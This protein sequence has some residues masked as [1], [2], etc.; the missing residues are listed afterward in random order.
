MKR[1]FKFLN[2]LLFL[3]IPL[4]LLSQNSVIILDYMKVEPGHTQDYLEIEKEWKKL[5]QKKIEAGITTGWQLWRN[6]FAGADDPYQFITINW[7]D[8]FAKTSEEFPGGLLDDVFTEAEWGALIEKTMNSRTLVS[9]EVS[10]SLLEAEGSHGAKYI[11]INHMKVK[12]DM[13]GAYVALESEIWKPFQEELIKRDFKSHWGVWSI[14]PYKEGQARYISVDGYSSMDQMMTGEDILE[15]VHPG[16]TWEEIDKKTGETR[17]IS[18]VEV[19]ELV[20]A[21]FPE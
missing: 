20:D 19:W 8:N 21:V 6:M 18:S 15:D 17:K 7:Y 9:R 11:V 10:H 3:L 12:S 5:H 2:V 4:S 13:E 16:M 1:F 14:W